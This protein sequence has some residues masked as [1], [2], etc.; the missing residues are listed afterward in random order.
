M[1]VTRRLRHFLLLS[2]IINNTHIINILQSLSNKMLFNEAFT[3]NN[4][5]SV[6]VVVVVVVVWFKGFAEK[7]FQRFIQRFIQRFNCSLI[8]FLHFSSSLNKYNLNCFF[9]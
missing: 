1:F 6:V 8:F 3:P 9:S 7:P 5:K 4:I 2:A